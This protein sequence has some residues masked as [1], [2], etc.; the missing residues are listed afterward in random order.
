MLFKG[1]RYFLLEEANID[2]EEE[3]MIDMTFYVVIL[4]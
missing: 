3:R 2:L 4:L 1:R